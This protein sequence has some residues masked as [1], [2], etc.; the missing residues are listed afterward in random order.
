MKNIILTISIIL[1]LAQIAIAQNYELEASK[2]QVSWTGK[3]AFNAYSLSGSL[4]AENAQLKIADGQLLSAN[5]LI[6][7]KT[8]AAENK[9]LEKHLR[10]KDFF[11][12]KKYPK[13]SFVLTESSPFTAGRQT[14]RGNLI[15][16][17][18]SHPADIQIEISQ[19]QGKYTVKG[20]M[21]IDRT[22]YG[23]YYNSPNVFT[24]LKEQAIADEF[25]LNFSLKF[26]ELPTP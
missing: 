17:E 4:Q 10:S 19:Q 20:S 6:D 9:D 13:A 1:F 14:L 8:L 21:K 5:L 2:S 25:E 24:N 11:E 12:V 7:M 18:Q 3:A 26:K 16:K 15:I 23:I 22:Q